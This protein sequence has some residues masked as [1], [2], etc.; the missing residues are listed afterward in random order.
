MK[1]QKKEDRKINI[2]I[3]LPKKGWQKTFKFALTESG[4]RDGWWFP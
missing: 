1:R 3:M 4:A 2:D